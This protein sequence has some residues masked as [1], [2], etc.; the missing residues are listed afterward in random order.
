[1]LDVR[2]GDVFGVAVWC[3]F[4]S[5]KNEVG[6]ARRQ[7]GC[8]VCAGDCI[9]HGA[10]KA[11]VIVLWISNVGAVPGVGCVAAARRKDDAFGVE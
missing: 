10:A 5:R 1:V 8:G 7:R 2:R 11:F 4:L 6:S 9:F 3:V